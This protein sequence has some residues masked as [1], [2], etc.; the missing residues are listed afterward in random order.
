MT[1]STAAPVEEEDRP[2]SFLETTL[3]KVAKWYRKSMGYHKYGLRKEDILIENADITEAL[4]RLPKQER[5]DRE[6][7]FKRAF[8]ASG[9][10]DFLPK[11]AWLTQEEAD[12]PYLKEALEE[13]LEEK[14]ERAEYKRS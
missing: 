14:R 5:L 4:S 12:K 11:R 8:D 9:H 13:V 7:R 3:V 6:F 1:L 10:N 2:R